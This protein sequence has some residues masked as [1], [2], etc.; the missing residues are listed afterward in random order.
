MHY[1][2]AVNSFGVL[3][4]TRNRPDHLRRLL[5]SLTELDLA[6]SRVVIVS[7]G[8]AIDDVIQSFSNKLAISHSHLTSGGQVRQ[9]MHGITQ[10]GSE[11]DW[12]LFLDDDLLVSNSALTQAEQVITNY[13][14][15]TLQGI[16]FSL[17]MTKTEKHSNIL[18]FFSRVFCLHGQPGKILTNGHA[19]SYSESQ[20]AIPTQW[21]NGASLWRRESLIHYQS[22]FVE[23]KYSAYEDVIFSYAVGKNGTMLY[24]PKCVLDFQEEQPDD[25][26]NYEA[27]HSA[28]YWRFYFVRSNSELSVLGLLWSQIGRSLDFT[29][30]TPVGLSGRIKAFALSMSIFFDLVFFTIFRTDPLKVLK[31]RLKRTD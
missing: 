13:S 17:P 12:I 8:K 6:I 21:L 11:T 28:S 19:V 18:K 5:S 1:N 24:A 30:Q 29:Y 31:L 10:F 3:V 7:S 23:A 22:N 9:K 15:S 4:A 16:G 14:G 20:V 27:F 25:V 2:S 26:S